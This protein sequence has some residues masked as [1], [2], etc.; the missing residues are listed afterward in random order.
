MVDI[1]HRQ[2]HHLLRSTVH[3]LYCCKSEKIGAINF[4]EIFSMR[5]THHN[6]ETQ[7]CTCSV[8]FI[9]KDACVTS[10]K[11]EGS[12]TPS[13]DATSTLYSQRSVLNDGTRFRKRKVHNTITLCWIWKKTLATARSAKLKAFA[14]KERRKYVPHLMCESWHII[15]ANI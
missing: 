14:V 4:K 5:H 1:G 9:G 2:T 7:A 11:W 12:C 15:S 6:N 13:Y 10:K 3:S 8:G